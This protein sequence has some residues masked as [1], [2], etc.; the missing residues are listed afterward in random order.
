M[1]SPHRIRTRRLELEPLALSDLGELH[2]LWTEES[3]RAFLWDGEAIARERTR[4]ILLE[5]EA[6]FERLG[7]G[8]WGI[9]RRDRKRPGLIGFCGF[10]S[11]HDPPEWQLV[12]GL[13]PDARGAG[14]ATEAV[15]AMIRHG[16]SE[17]GFE[18]IIAS[19]DA[20]N[21]E[22]LAVLERAGMSF[23]RRL[24]ILGRDT[25]YYSIAAK[26]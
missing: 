24:E 20:P 7:Y 18:R 11:F 14:L 6:R 5:N 25:I 1:A 21:A 23:E 16:L 4:G 10:W 26:G 8:M 12:Y 13:A 9:R 19:A 3:V 15:K 2:A 17:L 22:S